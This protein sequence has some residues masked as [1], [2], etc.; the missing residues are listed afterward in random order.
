MSEDSKSYQNLPSPEDDSITLPQKSPHTAA[1]KLHEVTIK[2]N[3]LVYLAELSQQR[4]N[5]HHEN[6]HHINNTIHI[7]ASRISDRGVRQITVK[8]ALDCYSGATDGLA[9]QLS[10]DMAAEREKWTEFV[11][12]ARVVKN[13]V[14]AKAGSNMEWM[15]A[16][17]WDR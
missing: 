14:R 12:E 13:Q 3:E 11:K 7:F 5:V 4:Y 8:D 15:C 16:D 1:A 2:Y 10:E 9:E 17:M 6:L